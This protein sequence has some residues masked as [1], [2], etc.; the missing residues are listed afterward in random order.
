M[1]SKSNLPEDQIVYASFRS[2]RKEPEKELGGVSIG[3]KCV[4]IGS[5]H[6]FLV[7]LAAALMG[8][9]PDQLGPISKSTSGMRA[10][11]T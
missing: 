7:S 8:S 3:D 6:T 5:N 10:P 2:G 9:K 1:G 4:Q 11:S